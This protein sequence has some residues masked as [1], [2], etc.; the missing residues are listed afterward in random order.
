MRHFL[1][2]ALGRSLRSLFQRRFLSHWSD[3]PIEVIYWDGSRAK[4][5]S[6]TACAELEFRCPSVLADALANPSTGFGSAYVDGRLQIRGDLQAVLSPSS[7][8][9]LA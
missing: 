2:R 4:L 8:I 7:C 5:G 1:R 9:G 3:P 6:G